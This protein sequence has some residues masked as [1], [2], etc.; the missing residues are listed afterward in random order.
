[1]N[2]IYEFEQQTALFGYKADKLVGV[3]I[4]Y[5]G[6]MTKEDIFEAFEW[7]PDLILTVK[8]DCMP[9]MDELEEMNEGEFEEKAIPVLETY[10]GELIGR[11]KLGRLLDS[12]CQYQISRTIH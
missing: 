6:E 11:A 1:M 2:N 8:I 4:I 5:P 9:A 12:E 10:L 3:F 7:A